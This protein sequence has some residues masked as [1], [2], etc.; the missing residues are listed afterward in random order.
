[1]IMADLILD[2]FQFFLLVTRRNSRGAALIF[3]RAVAR[4]VPALIVLALAS[5]LFTVQRGRFAPRI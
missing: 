5:L 3:R 4:I 1:M 2:T